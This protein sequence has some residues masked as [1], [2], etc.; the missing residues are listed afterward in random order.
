[1]ET[2]KFL[3]N[4]VKYII[5][6]DC[7]FFPIRGYFGKQIRPCNANNNIPGISDFGDLFSYFKVYYPIFPW[8]GESGPPTLL[9]SNFDPNLPD[10]DYTMYQ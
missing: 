2:I 10:V 9:G 6:H 1:M 7:D 5:L 4:K 8:S 3:K